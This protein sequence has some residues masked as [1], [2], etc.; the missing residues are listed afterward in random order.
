MFKVIYIIFAYLLGSIPFSYYIGL[1]KGVNLLK[2]GSGNVGATNIYR[3]LGMKYAVVAFLL[4]SLKGFLA[5]YLASQIA[6][7]NDV[8]ITISGLAAVLGHTFTPFLNFKGGKGVATGLGLLFFM[9]PVIA[10][11]AFVLEFIIIFTTRYVSLAS[12]ISGLFVLVMAYTPVF[13]L[14]LSYK[15]MITIAVAYII[16]KHKVNIQRLMQ[17]TENKV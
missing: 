16:F 5:V 12:I 14:P 3:N 1:V 4:D 6:P 11:S 15:L 9:Q 13:T 7:A 17:G 2:V 10:L 8:F